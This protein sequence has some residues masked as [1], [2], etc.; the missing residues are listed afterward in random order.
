MELF[1]IVGLI[2]L[3]VLLFTG[4]RTQQGV[5]GS[6]RGAFASRGGGL[7]LEDEKAE[8]RRWIDRLGGQVLN[9]EGTDIA[10]KQAMSDASERFTAAGSQIEQATTPHQAKLARETALEG[11]HYVRAAREVMGLDPGPELPKDRERENAGAVTEPRSVDVDGRQ[12]QLSPTAS[13][14]TPY[15]H[16]G[17]RVAGRPVPAGW[18]SERWWAPALATGVWAMGSM[19]MF[20]AMFMGMAGVASASAWEQGYDAGQEAGGGDG[21]ADGGDMGGSDGGGDYGGG[22]FGG[23]DYGGGDFGGFGDFGF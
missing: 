16:P 11:L 21:G 23:G 17:G 6:G 8:A 19:M 14:N 1:L 3:V 12:Y 20:N 15:Y 22:D 18:Y 7:S 5:P 2:L 4:N 13:E 10:S 9:L